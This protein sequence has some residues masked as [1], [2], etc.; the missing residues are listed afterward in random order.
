MLIRFLSAIV[1]VPIVLGAISMGFPYFEALIGIVGFI[2]IIEWYKLI[3][4]KKS[5]ILNLFFMILGILYIVVPC[6]ILIWLR[7]NGPNGV[8]F[9][10]W[11]LVVI[12]ATDV[13]AYFFG[14]SIGGFKLAPK[15][16]PNKTWAGFVG[17]LGCAVTTTVIFNFFFHPIWEGFLLFW[18]CVGISIAGQMGDLFESWCKRR[19][20]VKDSGNLIP[21]HGGILDRVDSILLS[22]PF[23]GLFVITF[24]TH[25]I[26]F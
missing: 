18:A 23:A 7:N 6:L 17:G 20:G 4:I 24:Q 14:R 16:S 8:Y 21:G 10:L 5:K 19:L 2:A 11:F 3:L 26:S 1:M 22:A 15:I 13:G 9:V 25:E 12:W